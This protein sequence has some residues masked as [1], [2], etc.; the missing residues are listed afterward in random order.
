MAP[1]PSSSARIDQAE[2]HRV[3]AE[4]DQLVDHFVQTGE[5]RG[6]IAGDVPGRLPS[7]STKVERDQP[8]LV[9]ARP[10]RTACHLGHSC[11][12]LASLS[13]RI[14]IVEAEGHATRLAARKLVRSRR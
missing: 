6:V 4:F 3:G 10:D 8:A 1:Q 11:E 13:A 5:Q 12:T 7:G 14:Q 9:L 2:G